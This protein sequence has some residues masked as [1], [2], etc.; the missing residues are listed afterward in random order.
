MNGFNIDGPLVVNDETSSN[1]G[2]VYL[3]EGV[4][5]FAVNG[6]PKSGFHQPKGTGGTIPAGT[7][8]RIVSLQVYH[9]DHPELKGTFEKTFY[10]HESTLRTIIDFFVSLGMVENKKGAQ[11]TPDW[12]ATTGR[13][14]RVFVKRKTYNKKAA[15]GGGIGYGNEPS[16]FKAPATPVSVFVFSPEDIQWPASTA[17]P[18][19]VQTAAPVAPGLAP[20]PQAPAPMAPAAPTQFVQQ[21]QVQPQTPAP[22]PAP[23]PVPQQPVQPVQP[24]QP[25]AP[26]QFV[27]QPQ[28]PQF[29]QE[30]T[31]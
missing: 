15:N 8:T 12:N 18:G 30:P 14:G 2:S 13:E 20:A 22:T 24:V 31:F 23:A 19:G 10:G 6:I 9:P 17:A 28:A 27:Q 25:Q 5:C 1:G 16:F 7:A 21:P 29:P 11:F 4:Y 26:A 3:L